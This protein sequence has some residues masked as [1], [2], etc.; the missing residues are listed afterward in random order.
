MGFSMQLQD[1]DQSFEIW[2]TGLVLFMICDH[3]W[4]GGLSPINHHSKRGGR[5]SLCPIFCEPEGSPSFNLA[6]GDCNH[7]FSCWWVAIV[8]LFAPSFELVG[9]IY[10]A[11]IPSGPWRLRGWGLRRRGKLRRQQL[12]LWWDSEI[13]RE[14]SHPSNPQKIHRNTSVPYFFSLL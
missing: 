11:S 4:S 1:Q 3:K 7:H 2:S 14:G 9:G 8:L 13:S 12:P 5:E 6:T 10:S